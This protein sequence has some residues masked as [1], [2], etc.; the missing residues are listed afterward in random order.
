MP[1]TKKAAKKTAT[2]ATK[3]ATKA[4]AQRKLSA[5][6]KQALAEGRTMS[7]VV[8]RYL[9]AVN[10]PKRRGRKVSKAA[11]VQRLAEARAKVKAS[12]GVDRV[13]AAQ[14]VRDLE[15]RIA[16]ME[17]ASGGDIK[18]LESAFV[19]IAKRFGENRGIGYGAWRDAGVPAVVLKKAGIAR[20]RG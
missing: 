15:T 1:V 18:S 13:L 12:T 5:A 9:S 6:H 16:N 4:P 3:K 8:D 14:D 2:K 20:T 19:K 10:T 11:L 7:A 17:T